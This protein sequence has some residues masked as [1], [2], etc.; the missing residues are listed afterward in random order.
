MVASNITGIGNS[1]L[2]E[3]SLYGV[4]S[5]IG[6]TAV[7]RLGLADVTTADMNT[8]IGT[9]T[10]RGIVTGS[11]NTILGANVTSLAAAT[12][13]NIILAT[14]QGT[15]RARFNRTRWNMPLTQLSIYAN[16]AAAITGGL[17]SGDLYRTGGDPD[18]ICVVH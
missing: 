3:Q 13:D 8:S 14:G 5:G 6:N 1:C 7:G 9:N 17:A 18:L 2:G 11:N 15:I 4:S 12:T 16:N 10:G